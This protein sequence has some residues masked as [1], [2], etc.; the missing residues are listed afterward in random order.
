VLRAGA[1]VIGLFAMLPTAALA[2]DKIIPA[3]FRGIWAPTQ[4]DCLDSDHVNIMYIAI[5]EFGFYEARSD[6]VDFQVETPLLDR[7][8]IRTV[9]HGEGEKLPVLMDFEL[10]PDRQALAWSGFGRDPKSKER[11]LRCPNDLRNLDR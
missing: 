11:Y 4:A 9:L 3:A 8:R 1:F 6:P 5:R 10:S 7:M 2:A